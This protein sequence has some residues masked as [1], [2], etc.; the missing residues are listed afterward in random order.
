MTVGELKGLIGAE[1]LTR[2]GGER[3]VACGF[4]CDALS[5]AMAKGKS[6]MAWI[7][8]QANMNA[9]AVA[10]MRNAA[11]LV[12]PD[13]MKPEESVIQKAQSEGVALLSAK[14]NAFELAG[15]M[16]AAGLRGDEMNE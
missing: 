15:R 6:G 14:G 10:V 7:T 1:Q 4:V 5:V 11:C 3:K 2:G 9:L 12:F 16:Y 8:V 13:G